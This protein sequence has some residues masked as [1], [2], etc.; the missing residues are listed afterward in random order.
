MTRK[1]SRK[2]QAENTRKL[3]IEKAS[4]LLAAKTLDSIS[5]Q[6]IC[7]SAGVSVGAF[8][9]HFENK[10][11]II[12]E[13]YRDCD[14]YF[15]Q[16]VIPRFENVEP[17]RAII[18][19]LICQCDYAVKMGVDFMQNAYKAQINYG[20][21]FFLSAGR[22]LP[23]GLKKQIV[24]AK[25]AGLIRPDLSEEVLTGELLIMSRGI[26]Y[27]WCVSQGEIDMKDVIQRIVVKYL[28]G[29]R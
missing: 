1:P 14:K 28:E 9:H 11:S 19:Y 7:R 15:T 27:Y 2:Q 17:S 24:K 29:C 12:I 23:L 3:L 16:E 21:E 20:N 8:Y 4:A 10:A 22:G 26:I 13:L 18:D 6:E 5:I 25:K